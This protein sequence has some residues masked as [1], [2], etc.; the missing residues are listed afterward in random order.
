MAEG[1][2]EEAYWSKESHDDSGSCRVREM[3][4]GR[5]G[6]SNCERKEARLG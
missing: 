4:G 1:L 5:V 3:G 2:A 6:V